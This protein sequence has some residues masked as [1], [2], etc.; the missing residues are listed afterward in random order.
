M[1]NPKSKLIE[2]FA[3]RSIRKNTTSWEKIKGKL[4]KAM[5]V[6]KGLISREKESLIKA[7]ERVETLEREVSQTSL[8]I[9]NQDKIQTAVIAVEPELKP[10]ERDEIWN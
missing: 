5:D 4:N 3:H 10:G 7:Q 9:N 6:I 2:F 1:Y 8:Y